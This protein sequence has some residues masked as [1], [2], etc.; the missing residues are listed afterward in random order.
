MTGISVVSD[1]AKTKFWFWG[2]P[3]EADLALL[4]P[5]LTLG[6]PGKFTAMTGMDALVHAIEAATNRN[7]SPESDVAAYQAIRLVVQ[8]LPERGKPNRRTS[9]R[10]QGCSMPRRSADSPS[11]RL[12][13]RWPTISATRSA[14]R[15]GAARARRD[16]CDGGDGRMGG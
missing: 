15:A 10:G 14:P 11:T 3:L 9:T 8:N 1:A 12:A 6:L 5:E 7:A 2:A 4:D 16:A 13:P